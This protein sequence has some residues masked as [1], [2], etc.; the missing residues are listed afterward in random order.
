MIGLQSIFA[1]FS[2]RSA[3]IPYIIFV[4]FLSTLNSELLFSLSA[5]ELLV[6]IIFTKY[7]SIFF[8]GFIERKVKSPKKSE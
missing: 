1:L 4:C 8:V 3:I 2:L 6:G 5:I 7:F